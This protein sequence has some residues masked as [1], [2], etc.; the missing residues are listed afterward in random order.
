MYMVSRSKYLKIKH[1][2]NTIRHIVMD[3]LIV[4]IIVI[5]GIVIASSMI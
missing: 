4:E 1:T 2:A 5:S 3:L